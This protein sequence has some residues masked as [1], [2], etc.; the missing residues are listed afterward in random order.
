MVFMRLSLLLTRPH[1]PTNLPIPTTQDQLW[2]SAR[3]ERRPRPTQQ[4]L[5][6]P[7]SLVCL[8]PSFT[9]ELRFPCVCL[10]LLCTRRCFV[11]S[12]AILPVPPLRASILPDPH[13]TSSLRAHTHAHSEAQLLS[14]HT[15][16][17][18]T[19]T[20]TASPPPPSSRHIRNMEIATYVIH[21]ELSHKDSMGTQE[22][23]GRGS[24]QFMTG[25]CC[26]GRASLLGPLVRT[27]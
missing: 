7:P 15:S 12:Y 24:V 14:M 17:S 6:H 21:G 8:L 9:R 19:H 10:S 27:F 26:V 1:T 20:R 5:R 13:G 16:Y 22:S 3:D 25:M 23:L 2:G 4:R 11:G 18:C